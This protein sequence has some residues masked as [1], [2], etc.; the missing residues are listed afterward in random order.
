MA[1]TTA[2]Q[3]KAA[4]LAALATRPA[5]SGVKRTW[6]GPT[7]ETDVVAEMIYLG[8]V[9]IAGEWR[10]LG[11]GVRHE[12]F[13]V[14]I[15]VVVS[16]YGDDEQSTEERA[17]DLLDEVSAAL[18]ADRFLGGLLYQP[19]ALEAI[20]QENFPAPEQWGAR[21][22]ATIRCEAMFTP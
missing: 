10:T 12:S 1:A 3:A 19:A 4:I 22:S 7:D 2:P 8:R 13:T 14:G 15:S 20:T 6:G 11:A 18:T 21:I 17:F 9:E 16:Q 5:L